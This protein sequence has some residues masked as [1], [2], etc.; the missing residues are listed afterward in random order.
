MRANR[1]RTLVVNESMR[2]VDNR[3]GLP[4]ATAD[5]TAFFC[6]YWRGQRQCPYGQPADGTFGNSSIGTEQGPGFFNLDF[7]IGKKF[8]LTE[9]HY[10]DFR[11]EF[12][13]ALNRPGRLRRASP[14]SFGVIGSRAESRQI[15]FGL[16]YY[17]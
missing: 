13:N 14:P 2:N 3:F 11:A 9:R 8:N 7:S 16:K 10:V 6:A 4:M 5:R 1:H 12:F 15:Q 17:F